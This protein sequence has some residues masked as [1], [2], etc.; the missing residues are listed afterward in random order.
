MI[1]QKHRLGNKKR[2]EKTRQT[3]KE[4]LQKASIQGIGLKQKDIQKKAGLGSRNTV[5]KHL[6][7]FRKN[8]KREN[9]LWYWVGVYEMW[10]KSIHLMLTALRK[11]TFE[12]GSAIN[13]KSAKFFSSNVF[14]FVPMKKGDQVAYDFLFW[15]IDEMNSKVQQFWDKYRVAKL[16]MGRPEV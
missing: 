8:V 2:E 5:R 15:P 13:V 9:G 7:L 6:R 1:T 4:I 11:I 12:E 14:L 3:I 16:L 10:Q